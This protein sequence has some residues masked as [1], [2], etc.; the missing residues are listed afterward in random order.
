[1]FGCSE[2]TTGKIKAIFQIETK[3]SIVN[4][5][6]PSEPTNY[7]TDANGLL[8]A[9]TFYDFGRNITKKFAYPEHLF[10][11]IVEGQ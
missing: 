3:Y 7:V 1:M 8:F 2:I 10:G 4:T 6:K 9:K 5:A 11:N